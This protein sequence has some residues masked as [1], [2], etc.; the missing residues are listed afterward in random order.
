MPFLPPHPQELLDAAAQPHHPRQTL[1]LAAR[2]R[3]K[4]AHRGSE[5]F[6]GVAK[7]TQ[8]RQNREAQ[9][10][11]R[12]M[13]R[14]AVWMNIHTF[15]GCQE[16]EPVLELRVSSG[17]GARWKFTKIKDDD[18]DG[19]ADNSST[20]SKAN[21]GTTTGTSKE[22]RMQFRGFLEPQMEDGHLK[23]W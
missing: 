20:A 9:E 4:H 3:A 5:Q 22:Y 23:G 19:G 15:G 12:T 8:E 10:I 14:T 21:Q 1:S 13:L 2:A 6:F 7:G 11:L 16:E 18:D 17:Y